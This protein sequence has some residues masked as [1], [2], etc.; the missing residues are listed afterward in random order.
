[1][2]R[3]NIDEEALNAYVTA[4][5]ARQAT[6]TDLATTTKTSAANTIKQLQ[7]LGVGGSPTVDT[8]AALTKL[9]S[10]QTL[11]DAEKTSLGM[12]TSGATKTNVTTTTSDVT[13]DPLKNQAVRPDAP[14]GYVYIW[15]G[16]SK[17][18]AWK[19]YKSS[20]K[21]TASDGGGGGGTGDSTGEGGGGGSGTTTT[22]TS[23]V[24][25]VST[26]VDPNTGATIGYF[27]DG[28]SKILTAGGLSKVET[29]AYALLEDT[30]RNYGLDS[31]VPKIKEFMQ[32]NLGSEQAALQLKQTQEYKTR[33]AGNQ[34]RLAAGQNVLSE[35]E[36]LNLENSYINTLSAYGLSGYFGKDRT[37]QVA[38]MAKVIGGDVSATEFADRVSTVVN[39]VQKGDPMIKAQLKAYYNIDDADLVNYYLDPSKDNL[40][41]LKQK[42]LSAEIGAAGA[43]QGLGVQKTTAEALAAQGVTQA[44]AIQGYKTVAE[45]LPIGQKLSDIYGEAKVGY[46]QAMAEAET[47]GT[48]GAASAQRKRRQ[49]A[50]LEEAAFSGRGGIET[51]QGSSLQRS[52]QGSF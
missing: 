47:F 27:S 26:G 50:Q 7:D 2:P 22:T 28:S 40:A 43:A 12:S 6:L 51:Q 13:V 34:I 8:R 36:Y 21:G 23:G 44:Q 33:F 16:S 14:K 18:G 46:N 5:P 38:N 9:T 24:T 10:G 48:T 11:T 52:I 3:I 4:A 35:A 1:M 32:K 42:T 31:L 15:I 29:D 49:L 41:A 37:S 19:L 20:D 39:E 45:V 25:L 30:F 17:N